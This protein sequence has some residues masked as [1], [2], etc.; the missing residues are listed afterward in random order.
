MDG[1]ASA[2]DRK[3]NFQTGG[4][5]AGPSTAGQGYIANTAKRSAAYSSSSASDVTPPAKDAL[6]RLLFVAGVQTEAGEVN[7]MRKPG[8]A[9]A[10]NAAG[11]SAQLTPSVRVVYPNQKLPGELARFCFPHGVTPSPKPQPMRTFATAVTAAGGTGDRLYLHVI[12]YPER[13]GSKLWVP[14]CIACAG[15]T[16]LP[17][18]FRPYLEQLQ[19]R[20]SAIAALQAG[21][22]AD[23][24]GAQVAADFAQA[25][26]ALNAGI[27]LAPDIKLPAHGAL[28]AFELGDALFCFTRPEKGARTV[29]AADLEKPPVPDPAP[30]RVFLDLPK[31]IHVPLP[32]GLMVKLLNLALVGSSFLLFSRSATL[33]TATLEALLSLLAPFEW[34]YAYVP[35]LPDFEM[36]EYLTSPVPFIMG[37]LQGMELPPEVAPRENISAGYAQHLC[38]TAFCFDL[39]QQDEVGLA[40]ADFLPM[41]A[42]LAKELEGA[43]AEFS[44]TARR[45]VARVSGVDADDTVSSIH[46]AATYD[47]PVTFAPP[48]TRKGG[49]LARMRSRPPAAAIEAGVTRDDHQRPTTKTAVPAEPDETTEVSME[50][51]LERQTNMRSALSGRLDAAAQWQRAE[52]KLLDKVR[53]D[54]V[55]MLCP[56]EEPR[57]HTPDNDDARQLALEQALERARQ[58]VKGRFARD[59]EFAEALVMSQHFSWLVEQRMFGSASSQDSPLGV[60]SR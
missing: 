21:L 2:R 1:D 57:Q 3:V 12:T 19:M 26:A 56:P 37:C 15:Q 17:G 52:A 43:L 51:A 54:I 6:C 27:K 47:R 32:P 20:W 9:G 13:Y 39:D 41:P 30:K 14:A 49:V 25:W 59:P 29:A 38:P 60:S 58:A 53:H 7:M 33:L 8:G 11:R 28:G 44:E 42:A 34:Q 46:E 24:V 55:S 50:E 16:F 10:L 4:T 5:P 48:P 35:L 31:A 40:K 45:A 36:L 18:L 22:S 23:K